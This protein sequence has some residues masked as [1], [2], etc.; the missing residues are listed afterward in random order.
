MKKLLTLV[1]VLATFSSFG[2][3]ILKWH[4]VT[5]YMSTSEMIWSQVDQETL[6][7]DNQDLIAT[8]AVWDIVLDITTG[9]GFV[10]SGKITYRVKSTTI[11]EREGMK[12]VVMNAYNETLDIP[13]LMIANTIDDKFRMG[14]YVQAHKKVYY[15]Q[16]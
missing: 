15:F 3:Q 8:P 7:F 9:E 14:I 12:M 2:Q 5:N 13:V 6:F 10:T 16:E 11:E 4:K 1:A